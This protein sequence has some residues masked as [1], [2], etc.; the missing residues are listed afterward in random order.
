MDFKVNLFFHLYE[1]PSPPLGTPTP[2]VPRKSGGVGWGGHNG[3]NLKFALKCISGK[4]KCFKP[5]YI[6]F[7]GKLGYYQANLWK[8]LLLFF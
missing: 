7:I 8:I 6:F 4:M 3:E 1:T 2:I 5:I